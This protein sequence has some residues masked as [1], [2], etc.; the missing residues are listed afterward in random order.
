[1]FEP[2]GHV[3]ENDAGRTASALHGVC[4]YCWRDWWAKASAYCYDLN[5]EVSR[6][7]EELKQ[8]TEERDKLQAEVNVRNIVERLGPQEE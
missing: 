6:L 5:A 2:C 8:V 1:M 4:I 3:Q 7:T